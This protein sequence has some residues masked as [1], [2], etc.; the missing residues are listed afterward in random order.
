[1]A[2]FSLGKYSNLKH[3]SA[4]ELAFFS[5]F[6]FQKSEKKKYL[7]AHL[8]FFLPSFCQVVFELVDDGCVGLCL[9]TQ[10]RNVSSNMSSAKTTQ[11]HARTHTHPAE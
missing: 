1:M 8:R 5:F 2:C 9:K 11:T 3:A 7:P 6:R 4:L 10:L